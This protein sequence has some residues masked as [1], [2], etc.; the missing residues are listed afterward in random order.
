MRDITFIK[1][2]DIGKEELRLWLIGELNEMISDLGQQLSDDQMSHIP[3]RIAQILTDKFRNWDPGKLHSIFQKG[4]AGSYGKTGRLSVSTI[5]N[6]IF[7]E[8]RLGR[9]E[10]VTPGDNG[11]IGI[12]H[13]NPEQ[14]KRFNEIADRHIPFMIWVQDNGID[15]TQMDDE[16][17]TPEGRHIE[18]PNIKRLREEFNRKGASGMKGREERLPRVKYL[19]NAFSNL[20][21]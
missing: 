4:I 18:G 15:I 13:Y 17:M 1:I 7:Q 2:K 5:L 12:P 11:I 19:D 3:N 8:E 10:N 6:W 9:G 21:R 20:R 16:Q 14:I